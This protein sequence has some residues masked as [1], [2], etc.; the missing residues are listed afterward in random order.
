MDIDRA[1]SIIFSANTNFRELKHCTVSFVDTFRV[2]YSTHSMYLVLG[3]FGNGS[4]DSPRR[5]SAPVPFVEDGEPSAG[6]EDESRRCGG[7]DNGPSDRPTLHC[8]TVEECILAAHEHQAMISC[9]EHG[10]IMLA[11]IAPDAVRK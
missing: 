6:E 11:D 4:S 8:F 5:H 3:V 10:T 2:R 1:V 7:V 9:E